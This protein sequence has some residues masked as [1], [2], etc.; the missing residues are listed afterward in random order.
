MALSF[1][2]LAAQ[3]DA[4]VSRRTPGAGPSLFRIVVAGDDWPAWREHAP[5][6]QRHFAG[7]S[8]PGDEL[9]VTTYED[10]TLDTWA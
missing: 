5:E 9:E 8:S 1:H 3:I 4:T 7:V 2:S 6:L 10:A